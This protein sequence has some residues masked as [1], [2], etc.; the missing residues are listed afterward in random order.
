MG[1]TRARGAANCFETARVQQSATI[2]PFFS[3]CVGTMNCTEQILSA[4]LD[5]SK[6]NKKLYL[7]YPEWPQSFG[8]SAGRCVTVDF[9]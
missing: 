4:F 2:G 6:N 9:R 8:F 7:Y 1:D 5:Y 3:C